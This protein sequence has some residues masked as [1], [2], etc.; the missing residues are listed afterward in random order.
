VEVL[1]YGALGAR[2]GAAPAG[3][4]VRRLVPVA[5]PARIED[6]LATLGIAPDEVSHLFLNAEYSLPSR[7]VAPADRLGVFGRDMALLYR[8]YFRAK[9]DPA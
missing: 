7:R 1:L 9:G 4:P 3:E 5:A 2:C 6:V 8:Q